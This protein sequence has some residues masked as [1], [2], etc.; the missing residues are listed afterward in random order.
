MTTGLRL[1]SP[2]PEMQDEYL[3]YLQELVE[4]PD[5]MDLRRQQVAEE[6]AFAR[7]DF[8][9]YLQALA[10]EEAGRNLRPTQVP[11]SAYWLVDGEGRILGCTRL[12]HSL[13]EGREWYGHI[14]YDIRPSAR[15]RGVGTE[16]LR[17]TLQKAKARH[18]ARV[19]ISCS[20]QNR[21]SQRI[22]ER[23]GGQP[24]FSTRDCVLSSWIDIG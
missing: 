4:G 11:Q 17:L 5:I 10:D 3:T 12:R 23:N 22:I 19:L 14:G 7:A 18:L 13:P 2:T 16:A 15:G 20:D 6:L 1:V 9:A 8:A 21:A 24:W